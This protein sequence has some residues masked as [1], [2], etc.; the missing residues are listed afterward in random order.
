MMLIHLLVGVAVVGL[1]IAAGAAFFLGRPRAALA[2]IASWAL[3]LLIVQVGTGMFLLTA[4]QEGPGPL[5]VALPLLGLAAAAVVRSIRPRPSG[6]DPLLGVAYSLAAVG[7][8]V[9]LIT[10]LTAG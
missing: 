5:H 6:S 7:S 4:T 2:A 10:A 3:A 1:T 9:A 8:S